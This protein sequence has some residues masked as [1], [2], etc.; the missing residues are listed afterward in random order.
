[1]TGKTALLLSVVL[2]SA[3]NAFSQ[4]TE[5][6]LLSVIKAVSAD[7]VARP[8]VGD[9]LEFVVA[10]QGDDTVATPVRRPAAAPADVRQ[11]GCSALDMIAVA[12]DGG[13]YYSSG[14]W[15]REREIDYPESVAPPV[16]AVPFLFPNK[17]RITSHY[18]FRKEFNRMHYGIDIA[19]ECGD[20]IAVPMSGTVRQRGYDAGGYGNYLIITHDNGL[21]T[22]YA[23]LSKPLV[24][25]N[26]RVERGDIIAISGNSGH[27]T[28]PHLHLE[29]RYLGIPLNPLAVFNI[30]FEPR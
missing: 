4:S 11:N 29:T 23:H 10:T 13:N 6:D 21:E 2:L 18:G 14:R 25:E 27:S 1:M 24:S 20:S 12:Y 30:C 17:S 5:A 16:T 8:Q 19:M 9:V 22:R 28:G 15:V 7:T 3:S 26:C